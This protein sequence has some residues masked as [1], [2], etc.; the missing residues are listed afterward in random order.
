HAEKAF[1]ELSPERQSVCERV[2]KALTDRGTDPRG[3]RR[4]TRLLDLCEI[5]GTSRDEVME[6]LRPFRKSSR[7]FLLPAENDII[8][9]KSVIDISH[10]SLMRVWERLNTWAND[11]A[12]TAREYRRLLDRAEDHGRNKVGLMQ[13]PDLQTSLNF[14]ARQQP[15]PAWANLYGG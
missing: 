10:E 1:G 3:I 11:E 6:V 15:T 7:S 14:R 4:P 5:V 13:D 2:F 12:E 8:D 9:D